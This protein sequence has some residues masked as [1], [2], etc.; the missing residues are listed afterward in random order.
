MRYDSAHTVGLECHPLAP[1]DS[2]IQSP[3]IL[4]ESELY[5]IFPLQRAPQLLGYLQK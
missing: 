5:R 1:Y 2:G 4:T 3:G